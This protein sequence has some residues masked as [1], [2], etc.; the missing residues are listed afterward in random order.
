MNSLKGC[1]RSLPIL[2]PS[3]WIMFDMSSQ[4]MSDVASWWA[5][6]SNIGFAMFP[7][8]IG[9]GSV[10]ISGIGITTTEGPAYGRL[11]YASAA[12]K[13]RMSSSLPQSS[14]DTSLP[15]TYPSYA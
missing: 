7:S 8:G 3:R 1:M 10:L 9:D 12:T 2:S 4:K 13:R 15:P 14:I 5:W 11:R 6:V